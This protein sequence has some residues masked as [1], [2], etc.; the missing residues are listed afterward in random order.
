M[1]APVITPP[2]GNG[3]VNG[4]NGINGASITN[5]NSNSNN[6]SSSSVAN[7]SS[8]AKDS[9]AA[10]RAGP[11]RIIAISRPDSRNSNSNGRRHRTRASAQN[12]STPPEGDDLEAARVAT[13]APPRVGPYV[14]RG[15]TIV[16]GV[17]AAS[18][19]YA[20][21]WATSSMASVDPT[22]VG[23]T[24]F[25]SFTQP[26]PKQ[27]LRPQRGMDEAEDEAVAKRGIVDERY[28]DDATG[29]MF[30]SREDCLE[31]HREREA[32]AAA[33]TARQ[34]SIA[35]SGSAKTTPKTSP[36]R[37]TPPRGGIIKDKS[38]RR[39]LR[40]RPNRATRKP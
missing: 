25:G 37:P 40:E 39:R 28:F 7:D 6:N 21:S 27:Q 29:L 22:T 9:G 12:P 34:A 1:I 16:E 13:R 5:G 4:V 23:N 31:W 36:K 3:R 2:T 20:S 26:Y 38:P 18:G 32:K 19:A 33:E 8:A 10:V 15:S 17:F 14:G 35:S 24:A 30:A 11:R